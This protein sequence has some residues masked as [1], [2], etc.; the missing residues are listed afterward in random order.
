MNKGKCFHVLNSA[1]VNTSS[2]KYCTDL[3]DFVHTELFCYFAVKL[4]NVLQ[5]C[6]MVIECY[7]VTSIHSLSNEDSNCLLMLNTIVRKPNYIFFHAH[8]NKCS[9]SVILNNKSAP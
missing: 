2:F 7:N 6:S 9:R 4:Q 8:L 3:M 1:F 5:N